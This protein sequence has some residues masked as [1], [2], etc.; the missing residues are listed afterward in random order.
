MTDDYHSVSVKAETTTKVALTFHQPHRLGRIIV[1]LGQHEIGF[2]FPPV[3]MDRL[4][5]GPW[6]WRF[7]LATLYPRE[8]TA[9]SELAAKNALLAEA[10]DWLQKAGVG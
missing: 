2:I 5:T 8:G 9:K 1:M 3:S 7:T 6:R 4:T 10:R